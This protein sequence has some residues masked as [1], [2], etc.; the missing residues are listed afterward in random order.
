MAAVEGRSDGFAQMDRVM[1]NPVPEDEKL[2]RRGS[3]GSLRSFASRSHSR[4]HSPQQRSH[5]PT[6][7]QDASRMAALE[8]RTDGFAQMDRAM[9]TRS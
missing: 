9:S 7:T 6:T 4:S 3:L 2:S 5:S 1:S 8:G